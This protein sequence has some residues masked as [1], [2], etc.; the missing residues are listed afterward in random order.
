MCIGSCQFS[1]LSNSCMSVTGYMDTYK[2]HMQP[3]GPIERCTI[4]QTNDYYN[5]SS[6]VFV[7]AH[8]GVL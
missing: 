5:Y 6:S 8:I 4:N 1:N 2:R 3:Y 7:G